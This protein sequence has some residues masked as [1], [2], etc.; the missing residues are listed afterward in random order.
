MHTTLPFAQACDRAT[1]DRV[2]ELHYEWIRRGLA[3]AA[4]PETPYY[5]A[6]AWNSGLAAVVSGRAPRAAHRYAERA[7]NLAGVLQQERSF[8]AAGR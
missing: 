7:E 6:L 5:I 1:S 4:L 2:A 8:A 3:R